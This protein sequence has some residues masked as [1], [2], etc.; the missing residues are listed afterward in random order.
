MTNIV[1]E[2]VNV[3]AFYFAG[4]EMK[5][6]PRSIEYQ[7]RAV[8]F[9]DG[10]RMLVQRGQQLVQ[11]FDMNGADGSTYHLRQEGDQWTLIGTRAGA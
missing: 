11:I 3:S 6:F 2:P 10:L 5:T 8:T 9:A 4:R 1:N 7:G